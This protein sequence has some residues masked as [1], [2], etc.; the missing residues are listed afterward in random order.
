[1]G[2]LDLSSCTSGA[3]LILSNPHF[4][5]TSQVIAK[6]VVGMSPNE[7]LHESYVEIEPVQFISM[8][9]YKNC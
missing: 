2:I 6:S 8:K 4:R 5:R 3:P 1:M 7:E 9:W